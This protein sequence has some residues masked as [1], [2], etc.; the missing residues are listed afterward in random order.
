LELRRMN[1]SPDVMFPT[2][3]PGPRAG[4][5]E[6]V[7]SWPHGGVGLLASVATLAEVD[8]ALALGADIVDLKDPARGA[9][10]AWPAALL[11]EAVGLAGGRRPVS[12]TVGD[13]PMAPEL[14]AAAA[15]RT[16]ASGVDIVKVGFFAGG[17]HEACARA[18]APVAGAGVRLVAVLMADQ[19]PDL[20]IVTALA[21][22]GFFGAMLD[23]ADKRAGGLRRHLGEAA[24]AGF[25]ADARGRGLRAGLAGSLGIDDIGPLVGLGPDYL[26]FRGALCGGRRTAGLDPVAFASVRAALAAAAR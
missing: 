21:D 18:L 11:P 22:A 8:Q 7:A 2:A 10:G 4:D 19:R 1:A 24:L 23:T 5:D 9:L 14:L 3:S 20:G 25:V 13:L 26:G 17:D 15:R 12:A 6:H 16:A